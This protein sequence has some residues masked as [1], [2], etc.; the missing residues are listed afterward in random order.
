P[1][2]PGQAFAPLLLDRL[3]AC[4]ERRE[5]AIIFLN[6]RG[7]ST[8]VQCEDCGYVYPCPNCSVILTYHRQE[9]VLRCHYCGHREGTVEACPECR[10]RNFLFGGMGTQ[11]VESQLRTHF[12][13][14]RI[15]RMDM[16][17]TRRRGAHGEMIGA[18]ER[19][20][21]DILVG[22]QMV[23]KGLDFPGVTLVGVLL[24][25]REMAIPDFRGQERAF[26]L[27]TQVAGRAGRGSRPGQVIFQTY[28]PEHF[29]IQTAAR[30]D[31]E[32]FYVA[33]VEERRVLGFPPFTRQAHLM[34]DDP[35]AE[36]VADYAR[37][38]YDHLAQW[39]ESS[40]LQGVKLFGP[41][42]MPLERLKGRYRWHV[43]ARA[44]SVRALKPVLEETLSWD[45]RQRRRVRL[46]IDVD[47]LHSL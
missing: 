36:R 32:A 7:H 42:P 21:V 24:A 31:Y 15:V 12:P 18:F 35:K 41:A 44:G 28:M 45:K 4:L 16:D 46:I 29:V 26:Q 30:Q 33:E 14:A 23:G 27:L 1:R 13:H 11:K 5:Q 25:D 22:T 43:T 10:G 37:R 3:R 9:K 47:P 20:E 2:L 38:L 39:A 19:G 40:S 17:T 6:R 34:L 8:S